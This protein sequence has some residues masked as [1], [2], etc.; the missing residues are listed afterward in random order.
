LKIYVVTL[1]S[2][3]QFSR[4]NRVPKCAAGQHE[5][6]GKNAEAMI[7]QCLEAYYRDSRGAND[8]FN[9]IPFVSMYPSE[10]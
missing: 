4:A 1:E 3:S 5:V 6:S 2:I 8:E 9:I 10:I 7:Y